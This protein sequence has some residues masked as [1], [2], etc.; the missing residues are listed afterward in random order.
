MG[1]VVE[2]GTVFHFKKFAK[3]LIN[4][5]IIKIKII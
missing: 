5:K 2:N 3:F 1:A 4:L